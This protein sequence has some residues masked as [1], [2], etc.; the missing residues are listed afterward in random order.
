MLGWTEVWRWMLRALGSQRVGGPS[1]LSSSWQCH[2]SSEQ[3][4]SGWRDRDEQEIVGIRLSHSNSVIFTLNSTAFNS[5]R[6]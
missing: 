4:K 1:Q 6:R 5:S 3:E 2:S